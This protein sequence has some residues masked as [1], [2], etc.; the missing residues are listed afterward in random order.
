MACK[1]SLPLITEA[2]EM[3]EIDEIQTYIGK[4]GPANYTMI[5]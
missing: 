3:Y 4:K 2:N 5:T 1:Y